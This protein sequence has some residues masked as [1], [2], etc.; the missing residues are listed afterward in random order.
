MNLEPIFF[1]L[2]AGVAVL[3]ALLMLTRRNT[4]SAAICLI[5]CFLSFAG[6]YMVLDAPLVAVMQVLVYAGA[7]MMLI[8]FVIMTVDTKETEL[9]KERPV[10]LGSVVAAAI[11]IVSIALLSFS[12]REIP[13]GWGA[14]PDQTFGTVADI[15]RVLFTVHI[16]NFEMISLLLLVALVGALVLAKKRND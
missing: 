6:L 12:I 14:A 8:I 11:V 5:V 4:L 3:F 13:R 9:K 10:I 7:I 2:Y 16:L 15:G 1:Y